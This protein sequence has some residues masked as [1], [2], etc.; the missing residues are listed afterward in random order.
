MGDFGH[1]MRV[2]V[3]LMFDEG[4]TGVAGYYSSDCE[5][6]GGAEGPGA[7]GMLAESV[8]LLQKKLC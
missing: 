3:V 1:S 2:S 8:T 6:L 7:D 5:Q 4:A